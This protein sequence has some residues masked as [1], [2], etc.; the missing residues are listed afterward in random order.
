[1]TPTPETDALVQRHAED[2][3]QA[4]RLTEA[5]Q[6][7]TAA[8]TRGDHTTVIAIKHQFPTLT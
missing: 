4:R 3:A 2:E 8:R 5:A 1:M 7:L 6:A